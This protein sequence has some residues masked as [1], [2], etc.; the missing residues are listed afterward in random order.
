MSR[1]YI[2]AIS[3]VATFA[4]GL[5]FTNAGDVGLVERGNR[6]VV[7][8]LNSEAPFSSETQPGPRCDNEA[9]S[10]VILFELDGLESG[11]TPEIE[12]TKVDTGETIHLGVQRLPATIGNC[13]SPASGG[14]VKVCFESELGYEYRID[15]DQDKK[16]SFIR[17]LG[18]EAWPQRIKI[19]GLSQ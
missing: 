5:L 13:D 10:W 2:L 1:L 6:L 15:V 14:Q 3:F 11:D 8:W 4:L 18:C 12:I 17:E 7:S 9:G 19:A 16:V